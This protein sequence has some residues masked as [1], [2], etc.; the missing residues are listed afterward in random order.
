MPAIPG[1]GLGDQTCT[2]LWLAVAGAGL[3]SEVV[4]GGGAKGGC[5]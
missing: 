3:G 2:D 5:R 1:P 4:T